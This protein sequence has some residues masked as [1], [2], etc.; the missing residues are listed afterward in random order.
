MNNVAAKPKRRA[1][2][3]TTPDPIEIAMEAEASG[4]APQGVAAGLL[5]D[6]RRLI[7][8]QIAGARAAFALRALAGATVLLAV[9]VLGVLAF[10]A[11]RTSELVVHALSVP[12]ALAEQG[13]TG[14]AVAAMV[15]DRTS[16]LER[17]SND[18]FVA[19]VTDGW[20]QRTRIEIPQTG[21]SVQDF[22]QALREWL[23]DIVGVTGDVRLA[24]ANVRVAL[25]ARGISTSAEGPVADIDAVAARAADALHA[26]IRPITHALQLLQAAQ[27]DADAAEALLRPV[28]QSDQTSRL[29]W[30]RA[31]AV[32]AGVLSQ[33]DDHAGAERLYVLV[34]REAPDAKLR[35]AGYTNAFQIA[36]R[37]GHGASARAYLRGLVREPLGRETLLQWRAVL[38][39]WEDDPLEAERLVRK[40]QIGIATQPF[41]II[42]ARL[43]EI[44]RAITIG[45]PRGPMTQALVTAEDWP[46]LLLRLE[47]PSGETVTDTPNFDPYWALALA[48]LGRPAEAAVYAKRTPLDCYRCVLSRAEV[49]EAQGDR[50]GADRW[51]AEAI[52]QDPEGA[53]AYVAWGRAQLARGDQP[54]GIATLTRAAKVAPRLADPQVYWAEALLAQGDAKAAA[55]KFAEAAKLAPRW[56]RLHLKWGEALAKLGK[57]DEARAKWQAAA[58]MDLTPA[59][60]AELKAKRAS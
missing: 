31:T 51:F 44:S 50:A 42:Y 5:A 57:A 9:I 20:A 17:E 16:A 43:H 30:Y 7:G 58:S 15:L 56:G 48:K 10:R 46:G 26:R 40:T 22:D 38:A 24:G 6:Q 32:L 19:P 13:V 54:R 1:K 23:G 21:L 27:P 37:A 39:R 18:V 35:A 55:A 25:H 14:A 28:L 34:A 11:S 4:S 45:G 52:R 36:R 8:W 60:R 29:D 33:R 59:E 2:A 12:P 3:P 47:N 41:A 49:A 53:L